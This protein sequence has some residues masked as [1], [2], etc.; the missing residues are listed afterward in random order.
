MAP[1]GLSFIERLSGF[2]DSL[3]SDFLKKRGRDLNP[4]QPEI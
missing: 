4:Q 3:V 2:Y 1:G